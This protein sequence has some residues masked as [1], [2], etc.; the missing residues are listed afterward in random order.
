MNTDKK[1]F[2]NLCLSVSICGLFLLCSAASAQ[3]GATITGTITDPD[4]RHVEHAT[5]LLKSSATGKVSEIRGSDQGTYVFSKLS[6]GFYDLTIPYLGFTFKGQ[7]RK[8]IAVKPG[9]T[10][11]LDLR[12]EWAGNLGTPGDDFIEFNHSKLAPPGKPAPRAADGNPELS[13]VWQAKRFAD[14]D[15]AELSP[16]AEEIVKQREANHGVE[17]PGNVCLPDDPLLSLPLLYKIVQTPKVIVLMW[18]GGTTPNFRQVFLDQHDHSKALDPSWLG[19]SVA[20]W[21]QDTL[22][23]DTAV[24]NDRSW[25]GIYPHTEKLH[26]TERWHRPEL[27]RLD[28]EFTVE[29]PDTFTKPW[30]THATWDLDLNEEIHEYICNENEA[31]AKHMKA[32]PRPQGSGQK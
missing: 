19:H 7:E 27:A 14:Q 10:V 21:E 8:G 24:F 18:E 6:P 26:V 12:L 29:D 17:R 16:R 25:L 22:V 13:G 1:N 28:K 4:G 3:N 15:E 2:P 9:E 5:V 23:V 32:E 31:D 30:K 20:K 11:R